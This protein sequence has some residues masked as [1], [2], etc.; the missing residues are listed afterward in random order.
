M[1]WLRPFLNFPLWIVGALCLF[2]AGADFE[3]L[4]DT[5]DQVT[6]AMYVQWVGGFI[7]AWLACGFMRWVIRSIARGTV[8]VPVKPVPAPVPAPQPAKAT[9][10]KPA[11]ATPPEDA[12]LTAA[13][14][15][16][17]KAYKGDA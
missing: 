10:G 6:Q 9:W 4:N 7:A 3:L 14:A 5:P 17:L 2:I 1:R 11:A 13:A 15:A 12:R 8:A 16:F